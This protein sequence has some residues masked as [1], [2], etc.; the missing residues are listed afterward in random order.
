MDEGGLQGGDLVQQL[1]KRRDQIATDPTRQA[2]GVSAQVGY[3]AI[4]PFE[5]DGNARVDESTRDRHGG[6]HGLDHQFDHGSACR[7]VVLSHAV[8]PASCGLTAEVA[9]GGPS[10]EGAAPALEKLLSART[11]RRFTRC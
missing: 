8:H 6:S 4:Q 7:L 10:V 11:F 1:G 5:I 9:G 3:L 2:D